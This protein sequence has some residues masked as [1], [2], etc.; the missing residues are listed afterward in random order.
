MHSLEGWA[1]ILQFDLERNGHRS[2]LDTCFM[3]VGK[4]YNTN[5]RAV[6]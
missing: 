4:G 6:T 2:G 3:L 1:C 5:L